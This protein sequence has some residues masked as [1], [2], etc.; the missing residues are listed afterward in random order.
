[1]KIKKQ[2]LIKQ[3]DH[4]SNYC[5][6][7]NPKIYHQNFNSSYKFFCVKSNKYKKYNKNDF[8]ILKIHSDKFRDNFWSLEALNLR[9]LKFFIH[10]SFRR[11]P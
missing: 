11:K 6:L 2:D 5:A 10:D 9:N 7:F 4:W 1:M 8:R 3:Y